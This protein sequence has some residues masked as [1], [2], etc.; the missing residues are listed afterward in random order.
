MRA[1]AAGDLVGAEAA[2]L[3]AVG[4]RAEV[5][6]GVAQSRGRAPPAQRPRRRVQGHPAGAG[7]GRQEFRRAHDERHDARARGARG[8]GGAGLRRGAGQCAARRG[9][10]RARRCR[11]S[12]A[13]ARCTGPTRS[14]SA[15]TSAARS[16]TPRSDCTATER[17]RIDS[18][19]EMTLRVQPRYQQA[20]SEYYYPGLPPIEFYDRSEFPW[21]P[22]F[23]AQ[24]DAIRGRTR[25]CLARERS[26][27]HA[28]HPLRRAHAAGPV[29][30]AQ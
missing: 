9:G 4:D 12:G 25:E 23:E 27:F 20:P 1:M 17:R 16:R 28:V 22:E 8:A 13:G 2:L 5:P 6:A 29:A 10:R 15:N 24:T 3:Q 14:N 19:I 26:G 21:L 18:F 11:R 7:A 30:R